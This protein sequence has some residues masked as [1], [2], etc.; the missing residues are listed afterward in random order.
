MRSL[1]T[2][3][4]KWLAGRSESCSQ[5]DHAAHLGRNGRAERTPGDHRTPQ[6]AV[7]AG[8]TPRSALR[9]RWVSKSRTGKEARIE[10]FDI[11]H[12]QGESTVA[13]CVVYQGGG[14]RKSEYRRFN[15]QDIQPGDD[16][17]AIRQA[18]SRRYEKLLTSD[19]PPDA[20]PD[21]RRQRPGQRAVSAL[22][23]LGLTPSAAARRRQG[24]GAQAGTRNADFRGWPRAV[25]IAR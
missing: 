2:G 10:C 3:S 15:I 9:G 14:M 22:A 16:Y 6:R 11:S 24:R 18:V 5:A 25:T 19:G 17:A 4:A 20:D 13:A 21:R 1:P 23:E 7:A 8:R 12:T